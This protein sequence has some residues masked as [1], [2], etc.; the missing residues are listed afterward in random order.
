MGKTL[1]ALWAATALSGLLCAVAVRVGAEDT[2]AATPAGADCTARA[3]TALQKRYEG[4]RDITARFTQENR[5]VSLGPGGHSKSASSGQVQFAKPGR[6]RWAYEAPEASLV[7]SDG[8]TLWLYDPGLREAQRLPVGDGFL[9]GAAMQFLLGEGDMLREF[10][11][12]AL[13]CADDA[14]ELELVPREPA[15]Y[16]KVEL[17]TDP[18]SGDLSR[19]RVIDLLGNVTTVELMDLRTNTDLP[20]ETFRFDPPDGVRVLELPP[21]P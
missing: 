1:K 19:T 7:V 6:M 5:T 8:T 2:A 13:S 10:E 17:L 15:S 12:K 16:E 3:A 21:Q 4:V 9:S 11:V 20:A 18:R 14:V